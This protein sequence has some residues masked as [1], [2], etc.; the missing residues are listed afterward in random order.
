M[1]D[2]TVNRLP[3]FTA[4]KS[5]YET[6]KQYVHASSIEASHA[7]IGP[8]SARGSIRMDPSLQCYAVYCETPTNCEVIEIPCPVWH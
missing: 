5:L 7:G 6:E 8:A 2:S 1:N 3:G 4:E